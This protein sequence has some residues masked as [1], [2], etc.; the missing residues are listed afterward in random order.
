M[1]FFTVFVFWCQKRERGYLLFS[2]TAPQYRQK[3]RIAKWDAGRSV[4][5][6]AFHPASPRFRDKYA[7][8]ACSKSARFTIFCWSS[9]F[10]CPKKSA[11]SYPSC[12]PIRKK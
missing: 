8:T 7:F 9:N 10:S 2:G 3:L 4:A 1:L 5:V 6:I 12:R 11:D